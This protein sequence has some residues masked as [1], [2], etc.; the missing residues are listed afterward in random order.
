[1]YNAEKPASFPV[2]IADS[3]ETDLVGSEI[4]SVDSVIEAATDESGAEETGNNI[5]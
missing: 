2:S 1:M 3:T 5:K 4:V